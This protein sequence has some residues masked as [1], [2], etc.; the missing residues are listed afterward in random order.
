MD[1]VYPKHICSTCVEQVKLCYDFQNIF[2]KSQNILERYIALN[3]IILPEEHFLIDYED[4]VGH[5]REDLDLKT[6]QQ[7][8]GRSS[9]CLKVELHNENQ[10]VV[11]KVAT[12]PLPK[13][14]Y[15]HK[16]FPTFE[17]VRKHLIGCKLREKHGCDYCSCQFP[18]LSSKRFH[19]RRKH[20]DKIGEKAP[21]FK[22]DICNELFQSA[23][24]RNY[25]KLTRHNT[26]GKTYTCEI[27]GKSFLIKN[28]FNQHM[29]V[30]NK[31]VS[32]VI[33]PICGKGFHYRGMLNF[34][35]IFKILW[36]KN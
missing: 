13:C 21:E 8:P 32:K 17:L 30:H 7:V 10:F 36:K 15:C 19:I 26:S 31:D 12:K 28:S 33:C 3:N 24:S 2:L 5:I 25:H 18:T 14:R 11:K 29:E 16:R 1:S 35:S 27:C 6:V 34:F 20:S 23:N 22:C 9:Q 4:V